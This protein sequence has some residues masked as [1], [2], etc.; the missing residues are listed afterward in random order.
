M[1]QQ[2]DEL[3][4][5]GL[6]KTHHRVA[7]AKSLMSKI[8]A[9]IWVHH[10]TIFWPKNKITSLIHGSLNLIETS[11]IFI[12]FTSSQIFFFIEIDHH[13]L[14]K[15]SSTPTWTLAIPN[16]KQLPNSPPLTIHASNVCTRQKGTPMWVGTFGV[17]ATFGS[18]WTV[19]RWRKKFRDQLSYVFTLNI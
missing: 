13:P 16:K 19:R 11:W 3:S 4:A 9:R 1:T 15:V 12:C 8:C 5:N 6:N 10:E 14:E 18:A 7:F 17:A 2:I